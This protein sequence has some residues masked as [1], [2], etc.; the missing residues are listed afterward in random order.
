L[1]GFIACVC[2]GLLHDLD[3]A[4]CPWVDQ[5]RLIVDD[6]VSIIAN[7][8]VRRNVIIGD[9]CFGKY[10]AYPD[11]AFVTI[12]GPM[13]FDDIA[14]EPRTCIHAKDAGD[15]PTTP[16]IV[17]PTIAPTGPA[18]RSPSRAPRSTPSG[19][20]WAD[21]ANGVIITAARNAAPIVVRIIL[22][23]SSVLKR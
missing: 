14:M 12:G 1:S 4:T 9:A 8:V 21:A 13:F 15:T 16:P 20:P 17:P 10:R 19:T 7:A 5:N 22:N 3:D 23:S 2:R 11:I 6:G 18:A